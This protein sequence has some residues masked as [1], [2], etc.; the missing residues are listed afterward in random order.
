[1]SS[2]S[3]IIVAAVA[4]LGAIAWLAFG[5]SDQSLDDPARSHTQ[6][7]SRSASTAP[8]TTSLIPASSAPPSTTSMNPKD[9]L[10]SLPTLCDRI[11]PVEPIAGDSV[12]AGSTVIDE[13]DWRQVEFAA[14]RDRALVDGELAQ[15]ARF[16]LE[17]R[18][19]AGW[20][21]VFVRQSRPDAIAPLGIRLAALLRSANT[22]S[23][24]LYLR[25]GGSVSLVHGGFAVPLH[26][27]ALYGHTDGDH[28]VT[29]GI[30]KRTTEPLDAAQARAVVDLC[31]TFN[32]FVVDWYSVV[33]IAP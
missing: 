9:L 3:M 5:R 10:F 14:V 30:E 17:K 6:L 21:D 24:P 1:M 20:T 29:L 31:H 13:D 19:G 4:V 25:S 28:L 33:V 16:K 26:G 18:V 7:D 11:P 15:L 12:P 2:R 27:I 23:L 22:K 32:L 8:A